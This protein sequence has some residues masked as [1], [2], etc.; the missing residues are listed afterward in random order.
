MT[1]QKL[2]QQLASIHGVIG[3]TDLMNALQS[4]GHVSD[5]A[6]T[7]DDVPDSDL[8]RALNKAMEGGK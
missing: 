4:C 3:E 6:I 2:I 7:I 5:C 8:I 1:R